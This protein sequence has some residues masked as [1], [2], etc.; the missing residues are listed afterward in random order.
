MFVVLQHRGGGANG[1]TAHASELRD[2][3]IGDAQFQVL[4]TGGR[5]QAGKRKHGERRQRSATA[6]ASS[7]C[8]GTGRVV[9]GGAVPG[10]RLDESIAEPGNGHD[11]PMFVRPLAER[12]PQDEDRLRQVAFLDPRIGPDRAQQLRPV[13]GGAA[14][15]QQHVEKIEGFR[16]QRYRLVAGRQQA[17]HR[18]E[19]ERAKAIHRHVS[20]LPEG[21]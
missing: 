18:I 7:R 16:R 21:F 6:A 15:L 17:P 5:A 1:H 12:L 4:F 19:A 2:Q 20:P 9:A 14:A 11:V 3:R 10:D 13:D 8:R